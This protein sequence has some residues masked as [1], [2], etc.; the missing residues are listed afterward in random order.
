MYKHQGRMGM[1]CLSCEQGCPLFPELASY[2]TEFYGR[3]DTTNFAEKRSVLEEIPHSSIMQ[4]AVGE[5][6]KSRNEKGF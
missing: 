6:M 1:E 2:V 4:G 5:L 3:H